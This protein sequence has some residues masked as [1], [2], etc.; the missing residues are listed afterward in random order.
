MGVMTPLY[1]A[2]GLSRIRLGPFVAACA[3]AGPFRG[4]LYAWF[5]AQLLDPGSPR[6]WLAT[7]ALV[8]AALLP[9]AHPRVR[10]WLLVREER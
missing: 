8:A 4:G 6:F 3:L 2:A 10:A 9:L 1:F 7:G 5:G